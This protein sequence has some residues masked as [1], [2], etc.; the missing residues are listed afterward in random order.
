MFCCL[1]KCI[2]GMFLQRYDRFHFFNSM[3]PNQWYL[4]GR[5]YTLG[6]GSLLFGQTCTAVAR[7]SFQIFACSMRGGGGRMDIIVRLF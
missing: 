6:P 1:L 4:K 3:F 2:I 7:E 5:V